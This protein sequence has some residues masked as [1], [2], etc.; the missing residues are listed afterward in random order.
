MMN[1]FLKRLILQAIPGPIKT[2]LRLWK[3]RKLFAE[4]LPKEFSEALRFLITDD[5]DRSTLL[6]SKRIEAIRGTIAS[7]SEKTIPIWC[8]PKPGSSGNQVTPNLRPRHGKVLEFSMERI[9]RTGRNKRWAIFLHLLIRAYKA[10]TILE[11][12]S[13]AGISGCYLSSPSSVKTFITVEGSPPLAELAKKTLEQISPNAIVLNMSFDDAIE[14][15]LPQLSSPLDCIFID[16]H[17]EKIATIHYYEK[18]ESYLSDE[19]VIIFD[20]VSWSNDMRDAWNILSLRPKFSHSLDLGA[21]G[22]CIFHRHNINHT[23]YWD[24]QPILGRVAISHPTGWEER[25]F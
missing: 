19:A 12:G 2:R 25:G 6:L 4:G 21:I 7:Q 23:K 24:L 5:V 20:D 18:I 3:L 8:S 22:V 15:A 1:M 14:H 11:L 16:G 9:A 10:T 17:H 13:C